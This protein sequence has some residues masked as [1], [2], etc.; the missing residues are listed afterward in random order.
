MEQ[1]GIE[2]EETLR[3]MF[4]IEIVFDISYRKDVSEAILKILE[5]LNEN[6]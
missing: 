1:Y 3:K 2:L 6:N 4:E 5:F